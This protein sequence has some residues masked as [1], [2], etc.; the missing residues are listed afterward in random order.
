MRDEI[1]I[2]YSVELGFPEHLVS[3][4]QTLWHDI[5]VDSGEDFLLHQVEGVVGSS[6]PFIEGFGWQV[7]IF[8]FNHHELFVSY[9]K[10]ARGVT[11]I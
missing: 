1:I 2:K 10:R 5:E 6:L 7:F 3:I 9:E 11:F 4:P 8:K